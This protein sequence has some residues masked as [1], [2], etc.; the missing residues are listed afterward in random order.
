[1]IYNPPTFFCHVPRF[2]FSVQG[3]AGSRICGEAC[4]D[5]IPVNMQ[6]DLGV[7]D[8]HFVKKG[9]KVGRKVGIKN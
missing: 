2:L 4:K 3:K 7:T 9:S 6:I 5:P 1:M 8:Y